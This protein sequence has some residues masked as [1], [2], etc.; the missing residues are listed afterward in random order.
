MRSWLI[1]CLIG[2]ITYLIVFSVGV[3]SDTNASGSIIP[4]IISI[5]TYGIFIGLFFNLT[6]SN[7]PSWI[8]GGIYSF[9]ILAFPLP[10]IGYFTIYPIIATTFFGC[11]LEFLEVFCTPL[12]GIFA[13]IISL[14]IY[15]II[16]A[17]I[18]LIIGKIKSKQTSAPQ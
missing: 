12:K 4:G 6:K 9:L 5:I 2:W 7:W 1:I 14:I 16:G 18:G 8:K 10:N 11:N 15:F 17:I 13:L 3:I